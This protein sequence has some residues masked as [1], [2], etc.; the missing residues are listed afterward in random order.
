MPTA[1]LKNEWKYAWLEN[2]SIPAIS[3]RLMSVYRSRRFA[4][5][6]RR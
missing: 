5:W 6:V 4:S 3:L 1:F 2:P